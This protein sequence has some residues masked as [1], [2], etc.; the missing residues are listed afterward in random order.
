MILTRQLF[1][2]CEPPARCRRLCRL[3]ETNLPA[4]K[5]K[6]VSPHRH[7]EGVGFARASVGYGRPTERLKRRAPFRPVGYLAA[8]GIECLRELPLRYLV[9]LK[10]DCL[11][12][13]CW[14]IPVGTRKL[15]ILD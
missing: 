13:L 1:Q 14:K 6:G 11:N 4:H 10:L 7:A 5:H 9:V 2:I 3:R 12:R 15:L 8:I